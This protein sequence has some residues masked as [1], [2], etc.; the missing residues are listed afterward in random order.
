MKKIIGALF[1]FLLLGVQP[2]WAFSD[3]EGLWCEEVLDQGAQA[4][5]WVG[6][7]TAFFPQ[8]MATRAEAAA[9]FFRIA[10]A[11]GAEAPFWDVPKE[12]W[13]AP[14]MGWAAQA[15]VLAG[16]E[17]QALPLQP[18]RREELWAMAG[19]LAGAEEND[20][21]QVAADGA[22]LSA[23]ARNG[24]GWC[25]RHHLISENEFACI[26]PQQTITRG[27]L[28]VFFW[29]YQREMEQEGQPH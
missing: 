7:G 22:L 17:G 2:V 5:Y 8:R 20:I 16:T 1:L 9:I 28:A 19:R 3:T 14:A 10:Q 11:E 15:G 13:Y 27:E 26:Y 12:A 29:Q 6:D 21:W 23:W 25:I 24:A 18:I 4:G